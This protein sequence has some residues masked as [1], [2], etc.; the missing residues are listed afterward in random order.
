ML[1]Q[2]SL[3]WQEVPCKKQ[4]NS[5]QKECEQFEIIIVVKY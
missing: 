5:K 1:T 2:D 3:T 4:I